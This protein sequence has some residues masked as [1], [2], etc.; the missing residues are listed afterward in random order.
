M[1][2]GAKPNID[3]VGARSFLAGW[4]GHAPGRVGL[5][6]EGE[7]SRCFGF[8]LDGQELVV[9]FGRH[10]GDFAKDR[11]AAAISS[12]ATCWSTDRA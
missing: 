6:G 8:T 5:V 10:V 2:G 12:T 1:I 11:L 9:R 7:W 4:C 3:E